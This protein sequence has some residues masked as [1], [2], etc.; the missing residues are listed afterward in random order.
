MSEIQVEKV[1]QPDLAKHDSSVLDLAFAMD[2]TGS[3]SSYIRSAQRSIHKIVEEIVAKEQS[4]INLALVEYRDHP[5]Q[6]SSFVTRPHDFTN[7]V[8]KMKGWLD[9]CSA[10]GGGD[11][12][13]A[14][15]DALHQV[16]KLSWRDEATKICV[17]IADA[18]PHGLQ[19]SRDGFPKGC[20]DGLDPMTI[21]HQ[22]AEKG[23]TIYMVGCEPAINRHRDFFMAIAHLTGGQY[24]PLRNAELLAQVII[25]GAQEEISLQKLM[26]DVNIEVVQE[27]EAAGGEGA[28]DEEE[29]SAK[30]Y[31][32]MQSKGAKTRQLRSHNAA[33]P[34][35]NMKS[36]MYSKFTNMDDLRMN[37][38]EGKEEGG[39]GAECFDC[40]PVPIATSMMEEAELF[41]MD[42]AYM[43]NVGNIDG[44][45]APPRPPRMSAPAP[46]GRGGSSAPPQV[47]LNT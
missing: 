19:K 3:M 39:M 15:A 22:L 20:P 44:M 14:V 46:R 41:S 42:D 7:K 36:K 4:D 5:P 2:C 25:G 13:E 32:K 37:Y 26:E 6:D 40:A 30:V 34:E 18:P 43:S 11:G 10:S 47:K 31:K 8:G 21:T 16:L 38:E 1:D 33:L 45:S 17:F 27:Y 23:V 9:D 29:L 24:V 12:P 35:A 28:I